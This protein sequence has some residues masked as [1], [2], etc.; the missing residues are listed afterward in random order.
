[1]I[2]N[3][4]R[5]MGFTN[6]LV[7]MWYSPRQTMRQVLNSEPG[8][9]V[10]ILAVLNG[11]ASALNNAVTNNMGDQF[12]LLF[13]L[14]FSLSGGVV[15]GLLSLY[16]FGFLLHWTG[17]WLG[18]AGSAAELRAAFAWSALPTIASL[19]LWFL[20]MAVLGN[21]LFTSTTS[22]IN[23][24]QALFLLGFM[25]LLFVAFVWNLV[26]AVLLVAETHRI[27]VWR[28]MGTWLLSMA[29]LVGVALL[30]AATIGLVGYLI[31]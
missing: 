1:M 31:F 5:S 25:L 8:R 24:P 20:A 12:E 28:S 4:S 18:G 27:S 29:V 11:I 21:D 22:G 15:G 10:L 7:T 14:G 19:P 26:L 16:L 13:I 9:F 2:A 17:R 23:V 6:P 30:I 3:N